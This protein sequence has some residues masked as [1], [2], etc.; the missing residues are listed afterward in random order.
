MSWKQL[1]TFSIVI[2]SMMNFVFLFLVIQRNYSATHY[3]QELVA[4]AIAVFRQSE[5]YVSGRQLSEP[6]V[7]LPVYCGKTEPA[8]LKETF[9]V[10]TLMKMGYHIEDEP[11]GIRCGN[12]VG[13]FHFADDFG[14]YYNE[15]GR[16]DR[17]SDLL[18]TERYIRL[19]EATAYKEIAIKTASAFLEKYGFLSSEESKKEYTISSTDV[20]SSGVNYIV[21]I[22]QSLEDIPIQGNICMMVSGGRVVSADGIFATALPTEKQKAETV[23]L[24]NILFAEKA[25]LDEE[26]RA[27]GS[28][29]YKPRVLANISY[30]YAVYFDSEGAFYLIPLCKVS[31]IGGESR[32]YNCVSGKLYSQNL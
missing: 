2:L 20:Y 28:I 13:E 32:S 25:Y 14:F 27:G 8:Q 29:S 23:D 7:S 1:R 12:A 21:T 11:G 10:Q 31:Y 6:I 22:S 30:S 3:D 17:P 19:T 16:Y 24:L 15:R 18:A 5:L 26:Y 4:S 9:V